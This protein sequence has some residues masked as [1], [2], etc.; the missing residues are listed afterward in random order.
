MKKKLS[1]LLISI[2]LLFMIS[3]DLGGK[4]ENINIFEI[5]N[6]T[7]VT[8]EYM[9]NIALGNLDDANKLVSSNLK[10]EEEFNKLEKNKINAYKIDEVEEGSSYAY[11]NY[12][13]TRRKEDEVRADLD[14]LSLKV[15]KNDDN[16]IIDEV[17]AKS[18]KQVY[19]DRT[20]LRVRDSNSGRSE[21]LVRIKDLP[22]Q[23][24]PKKDNIVLGKENVPSKEFTN[25]AMS[26]EG[27]KVGIITSDGEKS[28]VGIAMVE[29]S[30][31]TAGEASGDNEGASEEDID[32][33]IDDALEKPIVDKLVG[34]D[35]LD[36]ANVE[37]VIFSADDNELIIQFKEGDKGSSLKIYQ[38]PTGELV[39][40]QLESLFPNDKYSI[41]IQ[42]VNKDGVFINVSPISEENKLSGEY[43]IDL[44]SMKI[45]KEK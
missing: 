37:K 32:K 42:R 45:N 8:E 28:F 12:K 6:A 34:Y 2:L 39:K 21:V 29:E 24:Y 3:C 19:G 20:F 4:S 7:K 36:V 14:T 31:P 17:K 27:N 23:I 25:V 33:A 44:K 13:I 16:Y 41:D 43:K 22:K 9:E 38:N 30:K 18:E 35:I 1:Y 10:N 26:F 5:Q 15:I 11:I 40:L